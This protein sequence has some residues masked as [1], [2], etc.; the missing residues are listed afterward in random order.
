LIAATF[1]AVLFLAVAQT[2]SR[3]SD[4]F[5]EGSAE[6]S[7]SVTAHR[8]LERMA[9]AM[10]FADGSIL[11]PALLPPLGDTTVTFRTPINFAGGVVEWQNVQIALELE[12][13]E[14]DDGVD[15]DRDGLVDERLVVQTLDVGLPGERRI[16]LARDV[17]ELF[18]GELENDADDNGNLLTDEA[19][20]S[21]S[22]V[23]NV[24]TIRLTCQRRDEG[25]RML[26]KTAVTAVRPRN[27]GG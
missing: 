5:D 12:P 3:A 4:A 24:I 14:L 20:L 7:L 9:Q 13:G 8:G 22:S 11:V 23:G 19:G 6:H 26:T 18:E 17:A 15:N 10:E 16:V 25:G 21:F 27:T 1:L 2:S